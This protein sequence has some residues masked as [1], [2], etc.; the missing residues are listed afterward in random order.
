MQP[1]LKGFI[2]KIVYQHDQRD[3][4]A[5]CLA[6]IAAYHGCRIPLSQ[7][8]KLTK[9][10]R[11][12][13]NLYGLTEAGNA[14]GFESTSLSGDRDELLS[15]IANGE[16]RFPFIAHI[17]SE[18]Q[19]LH[20]IV[21][22]GYK[23]GK[24]LTGDPETGRHRITEADFFSRW[25]GYIVTFEK[26]PAFQ[27]GRRGE[28]AFLRFFRLLKGQG[29]KLAAVLV[30]SLI[31]SLIGF[32][33]AFIFQISI[34][35]FM[36]TQMISE[37]LLSHADD[38]ESEESEI[39]ELPE[40]PDHSDM[41]TLLDK[42]LL[43]AEQ[44]GRHDFHLIFGTFAVLY[45]LSAVIQFVRG[46][47]IISISRTLDLR[48]MIPF[49]DHIVDM[50]VQDLATRRTGEYMSRFSDGDTIRTA[51]STAAVTLML[52]TVMTIVGG[53]LLYMENG[54]LFFLSF[55]MVI[56]YLIVVL[57]FRRSILR[58]NRQVMEDDAQMQAYLKES[59]DGLETVKA[60]CAN[61]S[62]KDTAMT[63][64]RKYLDSVVNSSTVALTQDTCLNAVEL[65]GSIVILWTGFVMVQNRIITVGAL[66]T[67]YVLME[68]FTGPIKNLIA[69]QPTI[70][71]AFVA[72]D[73][74]NDI[75]DIETEAV[76][77]KTEERAQAEK[78]ELEHVDFRYGNSELCLHDVS[79]RIRKG[80]KIAIVGESG[81]G[82]TT[83]AKLFLRFYAPEKG[84]V[85]IG[86]SSAEDCGLTALRSSIAYVSQETFFFSDTVRANL[87]LGAEHTTDA[88]IREACRL[89]CADDM[90]EKL[91]LGYD[92]P[93]EENGANLSGG[94]KQRLS[95]ARALLQK[96]DL[97]ILDEATGNLDTVTEKSII[98]T[99]SQLSD[100]GIACLMIAHRLNT[101][102]IC[103]RIYVMKNGEIAESGTFDELMQ[104]NG[105]LKRLWNLM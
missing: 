73:R 36:E 105:E 16:I 12:G 90:I 30:M 102:R 98:D 25:T 17:V 23:K 27:E 14:L 38:A 88:E 74:L 103:D 81:S 39:I 26:T 77:E 78:W 62:V 20:F 93:L 68:Y 1:F 24:F 50:P 18:N 84:R 10:D 94:E 15:G 37:H 92:T 96:P 99:V 80:E 7:C 31:V 46:R 53:A 85:L 9:T 100:R 33:G 32:T 28:N 4:G 86:S 71:T 58:T 55:V 56:L 42:I 66:I 57:V 34:D 6:M 11:L 63:K 79:L 29:G 41:H 104:K 72:A 67:F 48:I 35:H 52:D 8:R 70:Q 91:P 40:E 89:C 13:T 83:A 45:L 49:Y 54:R 61:R 51:I 95:I 43:K 69:L 75:L 59:L 101:V 82:K 47:M 3:C 19:L 64:F 65:L 2:M 76:S 22:F 97:L 44:I 60:A 5:A 21:V 87:R